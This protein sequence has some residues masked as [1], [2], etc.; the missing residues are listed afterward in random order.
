MSFSLV[1][2]KVCSPGLLKAGDQW[3]S[4][5]EPFKSKDGWVGV[6]KMIHN[7]IETLFKCI[8]PENIEGFYIARKTHTFIHMHVCM[9]ICTYM[10]MLYLCMYTYKHII[11][12]TATTG[13]KVALFEIL[14]FIPSKHSYANKKM[15]LVQYW[16]FPIKVML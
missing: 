1:G 5:M 6:W 7:N 2:S 16:K 8:S 10:C 15:A 9:C 11:S 14:F 4:G 12:G 3:T 13:K